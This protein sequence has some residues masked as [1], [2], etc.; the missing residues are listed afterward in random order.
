MD[1]HLRKIQLAQ[2][3]FGLEDE[4]TLLVLENVL[5]KK[6]AKKYEDDLHPLTVEELNARIDKAEEDIRNGRYKTSEE[7]LKKFG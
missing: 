3:I 6:K 4:Q 2:D 7:L 1:I 5:K